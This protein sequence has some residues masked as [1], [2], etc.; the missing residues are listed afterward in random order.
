MSEPATEKQISYIK[1]LGG[2]PKNYLSKQDASKLI[3]SLIKSAPPTE[4]QLKRLASLNAT[5][6]KDLTQVKADELIER[7]RGEKPPEQWQIDEL[8]LQG[9]V[10]STTRRDA[11][12]AILKL[13]ETAPAY[14]SQRQRIS[15]LGGNLPDGCTYQKA[16]ELI[17]AL[18]SDADEALGKPPTKEQLSRIKKL[19]GDLGK[20]INI[21]RADAYIEEL[22]QKEDDFNTRIEDALECFFGDAETRSWMPVKKPTKA[23]MRKALDYGDNQGWGE[24]W[25]SVGVTDADH[26]AVAVYAV[27]PN[28]LKQNESPP[29]IR[30]LPQPQSNGSVKKITIIKR[31]S[32]APLSTSTDHQTKG[33]GCL[34]FFVLMALSLCITLVIV[35][36]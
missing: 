1:R 35:I 12:S 25:D 26:M 3:D 9:C 27:A 20:S 6:P 18:E 2:I 33:K 31:T 22:E 28:L 14:E 24:N 29:S 32:S 15:E 8:T 16:D 34:V 7:L 13:R 21:W 10:V 19:G 17:T 23:I 11:I 36:T 5:V 4:R 30:V